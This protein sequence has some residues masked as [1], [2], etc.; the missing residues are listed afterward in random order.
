M[1]TWK[2]KSRRTRKRGKQLR[3]ENNALKTRMMNKEKEHM[4]Q[5]MF[6]RRVQEKVLIGGLSAVWQ[7]TELMKMVN[8]SLGEMCQKQDIVSKLSQKSVAK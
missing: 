8:S 7:T 3:D 1:K 5:T 2:S 4:Q 6:D